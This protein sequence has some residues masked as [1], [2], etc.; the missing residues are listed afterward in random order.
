VHLNRE[1]F[2]CIAVENGTSFVCAIAPDGQIIEGIGFGGQRRSL[3]SGD[4][5]SCERW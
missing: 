2:V 5:C 1:T 4:T 3:R